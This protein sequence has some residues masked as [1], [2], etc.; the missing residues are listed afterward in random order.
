M[1]ATHVWIKVFSSKKMLI[2]LR[3]KKSLIAVIVFLVMN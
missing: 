2:H 3:Q 1:K